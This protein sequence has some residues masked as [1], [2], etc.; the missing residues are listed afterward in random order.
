LAPLTCTSR[1]TFDLLSVLKNSKKSGN[2][3]AKI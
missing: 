1:K 2:K 3:H